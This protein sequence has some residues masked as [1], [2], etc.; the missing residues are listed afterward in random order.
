[1]NSVSSQECTYTVQDEITLGKNMSNKVPSSDPYEMD[2][3]DS[4]DICTMVYCC[5][6]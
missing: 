3:I 4:L 2:R 1:M 6:Q 5:S